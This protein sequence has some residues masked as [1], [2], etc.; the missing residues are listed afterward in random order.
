MHGKMGPTDNVIL[1][2]I[3]NFVC[4]CVFTKL[5]YF[6]SQQQITLHLLS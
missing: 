4:V 1:Q 2:I 5:A 3:A 6:K